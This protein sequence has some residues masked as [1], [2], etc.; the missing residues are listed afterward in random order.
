LARS[1]LDEIWLYVAK[2]SPRAAD[3]LIDQLVE[4]ARPLPTFPRMGVARP[5][6]GPSLRSLPVGSYVLFYRTDL[7]GVRVV[8]V[9]HGHRDIG[10]QLF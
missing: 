6:L 1:D 8:R 7:G 10:P 4:T 3:A 9:L 5:E 2:D